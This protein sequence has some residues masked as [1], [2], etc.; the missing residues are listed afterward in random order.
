MD[1]KQAISG[2]LGL[3]GASLR[4]EEEA[5]LDAV[6]AVS[7]SGTWLMCLTFWKPWW[8]LVGVKHGLNT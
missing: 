1:E 5:L 6:T 4:V 2:M 8:T 3:V 7:G